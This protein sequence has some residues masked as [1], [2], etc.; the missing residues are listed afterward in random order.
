MPMSK[1]QEDAMFGERNVV[2]RDDGYQDPEFPELDVLPTE[3]SYLTYLG[4]GSAEATFVSR[5]VNKGNP[6][7]E[8]DCIFMAVGMA[9]MQLRSHWQQKNTN[10]WLPYWRFSTEEEVAV[11]VAK[12]DASDLNK[13]G[14]PEL[15][16]LARE[17][18]IDGGQ[19]SFETEK[20]HAEEDAVK[21]TRKS[22]RK[23]S[24]K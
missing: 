8:G 9:V 4:N 21:S 11:E 23:R 17:Q 13:I 10:A 18:S 12:S 19:A 2:L 7:Y 6:V 1:A 20:A 16:R 14:K 3:D 22:R 15:S 5:F 24:N